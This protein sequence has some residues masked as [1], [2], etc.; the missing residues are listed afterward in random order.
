[1]K[2]LNNYQAYQFLLPLNTE[3]QLTFIKKNMS[4]DLDVT[5]I[6]MKIE[7]F[8]E[9]KLKTSQSYSPNPN[10][11]I[12]E[13]GLSYPVSLGISKDIKWIAIFEL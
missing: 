10:K 8:S 1:M 3:M 7:N 6:P 11:L 9:G 4:G 5:N 13:C 2:S 12:G